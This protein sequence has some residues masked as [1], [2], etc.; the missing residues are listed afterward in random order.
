M[1]L[2]TLRSGMNVRWEPTTALVCSCCRA[3]VDIFTLGQRTVEAV[4]FTF[5]RRPAPGKGLAAGDYWYLHKRCARLEDA[6][7]RAGVALAWGWYPMGW[8]LGTDTTLRS[9]GDLSRRLRRQMPKGAYA[10]LYAQW[11]PAIQRQRE[12]TQPKTEGK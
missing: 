10:Q 12:R 11:L 6:L 1:A 7:C 4:N 5:D 2:L 9:F 3:P 8:V